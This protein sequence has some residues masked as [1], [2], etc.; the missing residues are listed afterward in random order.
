VE[1]YTGLRNLA[2]GLTLRWE[3]VDVARGSLTLEAAYAEDKQT[4]TLPVNR[5]LVEAFGPAE[6]ECHE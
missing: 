6:E 5:V 3:K 4:D 2:G 1:I